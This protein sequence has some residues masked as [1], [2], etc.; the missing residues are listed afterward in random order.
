MLLESTIKW[1]SVLP[2]PTSYSWRAL[3][4][5]TCN[6][7]PPT[8]QGSGFAGCHKAQLI[9]THKIPRAAAGSGIPTLG[10]AGEWRYK[11]AH[12]AWPSS[13]FMET[14]YSLKALA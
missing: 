5:G 11:V 3:K 9:L 10:K 12:T 2:S 14:Q 8:Q 7:N 6:E 4:W 1:T 13:F